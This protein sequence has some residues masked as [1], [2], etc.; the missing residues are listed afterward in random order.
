MPVVRFSAIEKRGIL[1]PEANMPAIANTTETVTVMAMTRI[2]PERVAAGML[3]DITPPYWHRNAYTYWLETPPEE[4]PESC[5]VHIMQKEE[6][7]EMQKLEPDGTF[8][9]TV[10]RVVRLPEESLAMPLLS[11]DVSQQGLRMHELIAVLPNDLIV[12]LGGTA[13]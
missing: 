9:V 13:L 7:A 2:T 11:P 6:G 12:A 5:I 10:T 4:P 3:T 8:G 1:I